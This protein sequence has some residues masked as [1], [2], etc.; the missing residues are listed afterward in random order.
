MTLH[1]IQ[2]LDIF[3]D[4]IIELSAKIAYYVNV[5]VTFGTLLRLILYNHTHAH[6]P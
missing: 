6:T 3:I 1:W 2:P 5:R 4:K